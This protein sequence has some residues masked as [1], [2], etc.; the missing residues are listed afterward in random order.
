ML[1]RRLDSIEIFPFS[2]QSPC[3]GLVPRA[4]S[5]LVGCGSNDNLIFSSHS[6][7]LLC[8]LCVL[9]R[10]RSASL[11]SLPQFGTVLKSF[12]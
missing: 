4:G 2:R 1:F 3:F 12:W 5:T 11:G 8:F 9:P 7:V 10:S 6:P